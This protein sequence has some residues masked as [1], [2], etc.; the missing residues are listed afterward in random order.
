MFIKTYAKYYLF[1]SRIALKKLSSDTLN[2]NA[3]TL[4]LSL[5]L[6]KNNVFINLLSSFNKPIFYYSLGQAIRFNRGLKS[7]GS[8]YFGEYS[9][10]FM[11]SYCRR[12]VHI[13]LKGGTQL[14]RREL[15]YRFLKYGLNCKSI[16]DFTTLAHNGCKLKAK[17]RGK[18][19]YRKPKSFY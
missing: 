17:R 14:L 10:L 12:A 15:I 1:K 19:F 11:Q 18:H 5:V 8:T 16:Q 7:M 13:K 4:S 3:N 9:A 2:L 6:K